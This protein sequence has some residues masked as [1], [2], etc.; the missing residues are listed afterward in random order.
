MLCVTTTFYFCQCKND[1]RDKDDPSTS[2]G[3]RAQFSRVNKPQTFLLEWQYLSCFKDWV[4]VVSNDSNSFHCKACEEKMTCYSGVSNLDRHRKTARHRKICEEKCIAVLS[5]LDNELI[6]ASRQPLNDRVATL[7]YPFSAMVASKNVSFRGAADIFNFF[8]DYADRDPAAFCKV[9]MSKSNLSAMIA[10]ALGPAVA[11][12]LKRKLQNV[13][14]PVHI[15]ETTD[16]AT[17]RK[18]MTALF[19]YVEP[20]TLNVKTQLLKFIEL[21]PS[22]TCAKKFFNAFKSELDVAQ[23]NILN[24]ISLACDNASVMVGKYNSFVTHLHSHNKNVIVT[25]CICHKNALVAHVACLA[26]PTYLE[27]F[28]RDLMKFVRSS[29]KRES[30]FSEILFCF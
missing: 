19:R 22:D 10:K 30:H 12:I 18:W 13:K 1:C 23:L 14:F 5:D 4:Q 28:I 16:S 20:N 11:E 15:D 3:V 24:L 8:K 21:V 25:G 29:P 27:S 26:W 9:T 6:D 17:R 7:E 2:S